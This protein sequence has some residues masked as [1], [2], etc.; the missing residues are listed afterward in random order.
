MPLK[1]IWAASKV[2]VSSGKCCLFKVCSLE[3]I[4]EFPDDV[5]ILNIKN[6]LRLIGLK[7]LT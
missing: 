7:S 1:F 5:S 6:T 4:L 2:H 3:V